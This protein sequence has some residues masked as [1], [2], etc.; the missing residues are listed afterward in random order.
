M[1]NNT[2]YIRTYKV[3]LQIN[4]FN[5]LEE[6][7]SKHLCRRNASIVSSK[8]NSFENQKYLIG[9]NFTKYLILFCLS[10]SCSSTDLIKSVILKQSSVRYDYLCK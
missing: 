4:N 5:Y 2:F 6:R 9:I 3:C 7:Y 10:Y 1:L 8:I